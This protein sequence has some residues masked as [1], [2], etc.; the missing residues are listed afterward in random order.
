MKKLLLLFVALLLFNPIFSQWQT[1]NVAPSGR[2]NDVCVVDNDVVWACGDSTKV[3]KSTNGGSTWLLSNSGLPIGPVLEITS[4]NQNNAW[5][6]MANR[7]FATTNGGTSWIEQ[8]YSPVTFINKIHF[9]NQNTGYLIADQQDSIVGFFV[10]RNGG[11]NWVRSANSPALSNISTM[12]ISDN[13]SDALDTNFIW[14]VAKGTPSMFSR[15]YKLTGGLNNSW[16]FHL[17]GPSTG[18]YSY[19]SFKNVNTGLVT[20][21]NGISITTNGGINW[22]LRDS[23]PFPDVTRELMIVPG[24]DWVIQTGIG[25]TR[26]SYDMCAS[27]Q[28]IRPYNF[29]NFCD[30]KDTNSIWAAGSNGQLLKYNFGYIGIN[31]I[32]NEVPSVFILHQNYPNPFN[33]VTNITFD[34]P[35]PGEMKITIFDITGREVYIEKNFLSAGKHN[36]EFNGTAFSSGIYF[37]SAEFNKIRETKKMILIK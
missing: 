23:A 5:I 37:Y 13:G 18:Q 28:P 30:A 36:F 33:P 3:F 31:L 17:I 25:N 8:I 9:F 19:S 22:Q 20:S 26:I 12:W 35:A 24:T 15:F 27:W 29:Y 6:H 1:F 34:L 16:Q 7:I 14:F 11:T 4:V 10:T 32:N 21:T 2:F